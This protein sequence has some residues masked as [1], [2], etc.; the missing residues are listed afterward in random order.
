MHQR[1]FAAGEYS[2]NDNGLVV[3]DLRLGSEP[4]QNQLKFSQLEGVGFVSRVE[5]QFPNVV[6]TTYRKQSDK[7]K[8]RCDPST[9]QQIID[10]YGRLGVRMLEKVPFSN[11]Q[12]A[13]PAATR[14]GTPSPSSSVNPSANWTLWREE[15]TPRSK[16]I[17]IKRSV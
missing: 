16:F 12:T 7:R 15:S 8:Y 1:R 4:R 14:T 3:R 6:S 13:T 10:C 9:A 17:F 11:R 5:T 2:F